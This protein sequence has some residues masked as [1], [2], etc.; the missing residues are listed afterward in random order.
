MMLCHCV[1]Q[2]IGVAFLVVGVWAYFEK[3]AF[4]YSEDD[5]QAIEIYDLVFD[6]TIIMIILGC[7][8]FILAFTGCV[9]ALREN[10]CFLKFVSYL[11]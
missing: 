9:G 5:D 1:F 8:I 11:I 10:V 2:L 3:D 6:L 7:I 4:E